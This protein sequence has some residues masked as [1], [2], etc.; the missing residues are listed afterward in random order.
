MK[1]SFKWDTEVWD[2]KD[3]EEF[4]KHQPKML[5]RGF[6]VFEEHESNY[7]Y[8]VEYRKEHTIKEK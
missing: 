8:T 2:Y 3:V 4:K 1:K 6:S 5:T 7:G